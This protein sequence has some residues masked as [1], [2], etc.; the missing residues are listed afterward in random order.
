[1]QDAGRL[2]N[3]AGTGPADLSTKSALVLPTRIITYAWGDKYIRDLVSMTLP[4]LLAPGNLPYVARHVPCELVILSEETSFPRFRAEPAV[5]RVEVVCPVRFIALDDLISAPDQYGIA[6]THVLH[7]GVSDLGS[8][9]TDA[10]LIFL[11]ADFVLAEDSLKNLLRHLQAGERLVAA[12]SYCVNA[13]EV[14][15]ELLARVDSQ[16]QSVSIPH[17]EMA[18]LI[19]RHRHNTIRAKIFNQSEI[20][21]H[22]TDQFYWLH[23]AQTLLGHQMPVAIV[24]MRPECHVDE[25]NSYWDHGLMREFCPTVEHFVIGDSDEFLMLELRSADV[26]R[27]Q[28]QSGSSS[29]A[30][31]ARQ[32]ASFLTSY[33]RDMVRYSLS[34]PFERPADRR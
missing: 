2:E 22:P 8:A 13:E 34:L 16:T 4:A 27:D 31:I 17:R 25:P 32:M 14:V 26:A 11:N 21:I 3:G 28:L 20:R 12:P 1:M 33:Q 30:E 7:R 19:L 23:D 29:P 15:P 5:R 10:W 6:L 18:D 24:G 9:M